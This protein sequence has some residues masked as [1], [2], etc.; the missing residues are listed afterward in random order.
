MTSFEIALVATRLA[1]VSAALLLGPGLLLLMKLRVKAEWPEKI[2]LAFALSYSWL[3]LLSILVPLFGWTADAAALLTALLL[4]TLGVAA[5]RGRAQTGLAR[6]DAAGALLIVVIAVAAA[7]A[8]VIESPFTGEE[9]LD[10]ASISRFADGGPI[11]FDNTSLLPDAR[12]VY[13]IQPYQLAVGVIARWSGMEPLVAFIKFRAVIVPLALI[14]LFSLVR[15]LLP[16]RSDAVPVFAVI[17]L[18]I[19]LDVDTWELNSLF[20]LIRRGGAG[21]GLC[22]PVMLLLC[23]AATRRPEPPDGNRLRRIALIT[24]PVMLTASLAT[25]PLE[26]FP[27]LCFV[28]GMTAVIVAGFDQDG[29]RRQALILAAVLAATAVTY[30][31]IQSRLVPYVAEYEQNEKQSRREELADFAG[32]PIAAI[33]GRPAPG[34]DMLTR[35]IPGTSAVVFGTVALPLA[36]LIAPGA[37]A[38]LAAGIVPLALAYATPAGYLVL[39]L[40][41]SVETVRDINPYFSL[42]ALIALAMATAAT[43]HMILRAAAARSGPPARLVMHALAISVAGLTILFIGRAAARALA[44][45]VTMEPRILLAA[46]TL[47]AVVALI[48]SRRAGTAPLRR[49]PFPTGVAVV[50]VCLA[51]PFA[52]PDATIGGAFTTRQPV[53]LLTRFQI[54]RAAPSVL[55]WDDYYERLRETIAPPLP[56]PRAVV[57]ELRRRIPP[58]QIVLADPRYSCALVV[59]LNAYCINPAS[60]YGHYFAPAVGYYRGYVADRGSDSPQHPFFNSAAALSDAERT[61][62]EDLRVGYVLTDPQY[63]DLIATKLARAVEGAHL[64]MTL[65]GYQ[66]YRVTATSASTAGQ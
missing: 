14:F 46:G 10:F 32:D 19:T 9:A 57:D 25:H 42:L 62:I 52:Q 23:I 31:T 39:T 6:P 3:L 36:A 11:S 45:A 47:A 18:F 30:L 48:I 1:V 7:A 28:A 65:D 60:I 24:A 20:P 17:L 54:A 37:A 33:I 58:R 41:T 13:L 2:T 64:E 12:P 4:A 56:V 66:L 44:G 22:V 40:L 35:T 43:A 61:V 49:S 29:D 38:T 55:D 59:L 51:M 21:A 8:W 27:V 53:D 34:E 26:M 16:N 63:G 50:T 5:F 15:R